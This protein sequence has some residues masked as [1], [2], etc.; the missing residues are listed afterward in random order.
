MQIKERMK[1]YAN[2]FFRF[3]FNRIDEI[4][5]ISLIKNSSITLISYKLDLKYNIKINMVDYDY[6]RHLKL[7]KLD[8]KKKQNQFPYEE[9]EGE[10]TELR[11]YS[12]II[13]SQIHLKNKYF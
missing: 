10:S 13:E 8:Q 1:F 9:N 4:I 7:L 11:K 5:S 3:M 2:K 6:Q 12:V